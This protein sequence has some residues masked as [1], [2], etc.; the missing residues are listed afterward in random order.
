[1][2]RPAQHDLDPAPGRRPASALGPPTCRWSVLDASKSKSSAARPA[3]PCRPRPLAPPPPQADTW[4]NAH[5]MLRLV[6]RLRSA[7]GHRIPSR[8][9]TQSC[10]NIFYAVTQSTD[11]KNKQPTPSGPWRCPR[12]MESHKVATRMRPRPA[13][14]AGGCHGHAGHATLPWGGVARRPEGAEVACWN[15][16]GAKAPARA[17]GCPRPARVFAGRG[18]RLR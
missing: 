6:M 4:R 7:D 17:C 3:M 18:Q 13:V 1:M 8:R 2:G 15:L 9:H 12:T 14:S 11:V 16:P 10:H 5:T